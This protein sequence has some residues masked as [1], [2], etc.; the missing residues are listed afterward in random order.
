MQ[1]QVEQ[2]LKAVSQ[3]WSK[4]SQEALKEMTDKYGQPDEF[5]ASQ[6]IWHHNGP[7]KRTVLQSEEIQHDFPSTHMD[8]LEQFIDYH[9]P[10]DKYDDLAKYDGSIIVER[11]KGVISARCAGEAM[12]F[13]AINLAHEIVTGRRSV[14]D[15]RQEYTRLYQAYHKGQK[16]DATQRFT[17]DLPTG[18]TADPDVEVI[19][20]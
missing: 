8:V 20:S 4:T 17:F 13:V 19:K 2:S 16:E 12:N 15:A 1:Q 9:V 5:S 10:P 11:T 6:A 7:W 18:K 3:K 14:D